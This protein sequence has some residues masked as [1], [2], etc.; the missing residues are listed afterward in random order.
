M[1]PTNHYKSHRFHAYPLT[2]L[3]ADKYDDW[4]INTAFLNELMHTARLSSIAVTGNMMTNKVDA[5]LSG[6]TILNELM[7]A[8]HVGCSSF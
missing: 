6:D 2:Q 8:T 7:L 4:Y 1:C 3:V 5:G